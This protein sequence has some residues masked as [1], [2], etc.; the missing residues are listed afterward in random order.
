MFLCHA[1][2]ANGRPC[3]AYASVLEE[4]VDRDGTPVVT[5]SH[6]CRHHSHF[7]DGD[8][9]KHKYLGPIWYNE[10]WRIPHLH[11]E[12]VLSSGAITVTKEDVDWFTLEGYSW[13]LFVLLARHVPAARRDWN[14]LL[15]EKAQTMIWRR[16]DSI[17]PVS[18]DYADLRATIC[19]PA[20]KELALCLKRFPS[21]NHR[22][23]M[24]KEDWLTAVKLLLILGDADEILTDP[25]LTLETLSLAR[26]VDLSILNSMIDEGEIL[27][28]LLTERAAFYE[29]CIRG[30]GVAAFREELL[31]VA[32]EPSRAVAWCIDFEGDS[33]FKK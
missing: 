21:A 28:L 26:R 24:S 23:E 4:G 2:K 10:I 17:G 6:T 5:Y 22:R 31:A 11:V 1:L 7:F 19:V 25:Q 9:W 13:Y 12:Y 20:A 27:N 15:W 33:P 32:W 18:L 14:P 8:T 3:R 16:I 30:V 29:K